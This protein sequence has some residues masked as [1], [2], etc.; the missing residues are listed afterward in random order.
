M[1][2][3]HDILTDEEGGPDNVI[4]KVEIQYVL[5]TIG[6]HCTSTKACGNKSNYDTF[7]SISVKAT[8]SKSS[9]KCC[10]T[11]DRS[12]WT[13]THATNTKLSTRGNQTKIKMENLNTRLYLLSPR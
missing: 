9:K 3:R 11:S 1:P 13:K 7:P 2:S 5:G 12:D 4:S 10:L 6:S 8:K